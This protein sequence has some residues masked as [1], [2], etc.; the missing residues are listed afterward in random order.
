MTSEK[1]V[2]EFEPGKGYK[3]TWT[4][5][6]SANHWFDSTYSA[7]VAGHRLWFGKDVAKMGVRRPQENDMFNNPALPAAGKKQLK[8]GGYNPF[9]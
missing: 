8:L 2:L 6:R 9:K 4:P 3:K 5:L 7:Y 1:E